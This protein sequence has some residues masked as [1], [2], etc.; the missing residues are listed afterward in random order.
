MGA[1]V[2]G[3]WPGIT[4]EQ[5]EN[6]PGFFNDCKA[7]GGWMAVRYEH[8]AI[9]ALHKSLGIE[10][11]LSHTT[12]G[13]EASEVAWVSPQQLASAASRLR[14]L[15]LAND[16]RVQPLLNVYAEHSNEIDPVDQEFAQD[17]LDVAAIADYA[18]GCGVSRMTLE[19]SW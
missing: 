4:Q 10:P 5:L 6:Q 3:Y 16:P 18:S 2:V 7:W 12:E 14:D 15:V 1:T 9:I 8:P 17:L 11:L 19:V 13:M